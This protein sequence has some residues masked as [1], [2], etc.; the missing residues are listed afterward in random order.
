VGHDEHMVGYADKYDQDKYQLN[1]GKLH[2]ST[3]KYFSADVRFCFIFQSMHD[4]G[5][6]QIYCSPGGSIKKRLPL[7]TFFKGVSFITYK[8][9]SAALLKTVLWRRLSD[10]LPK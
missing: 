4:I 3:T 10:Y 7:S 2:A 5:L 8:P 1:P 9:P 6:R